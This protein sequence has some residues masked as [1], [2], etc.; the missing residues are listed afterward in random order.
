LGGW[1]GGG[2]RFGRTS[3][4]PAAAAASAQCDLHLLSNVLSI[5]VMV[6]MQY[7]PPLY[8]RPVTVR[9]VCGCFRLGGCGSPVPRLLP[10]PHPFAWSSPSSA[11]RNP[12]VVGRILADRLN[13]E[14]SGRA[15]IVET[16][17]G[18]EWPY[19]RRI[20]PK[21]RRPTGNL[22][23]FLTTVGA[24]RGQRRHLKQAELLYAC[25]ISRRITLGGR[26]QPPNHP[27]V[28]Q[29]DTPVNSAKELGR[30]AR[31]KDGRNDSR[32][33]RPARAAVKPIARRLEAFH[34]SAGHVKFLH[35]RYRTGAAPALTDMLVAGC[36]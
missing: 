28:V 27:W 9:S 6:D 4:A 24:V 36:W 19:R 17:P 26:A 8:E 20:R 7:P 11:D 1:A 23:G 32:S 5:L 14:C 31:E 33:P 30:L 18:R 29:P 12:I 3:P 35:V 25:A 15:S 22:L 2:G 10:P 34:Q 21:R 16:G 13:P